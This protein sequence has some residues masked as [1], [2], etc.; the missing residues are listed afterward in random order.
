[1]YP[2]QDDHTRRM[3]Q[4][5]DSRAYSRMSGDRA[6]DPA[7]DDG[8]GAEGGYDDGY[9]EPRQSRR[10]PAIDVGKFVGSVAAT[11]LVAAI[12][13]W[14]IAWVVDAVFSRFGHQWANGGNTPTMY[15]V[16][17]AVAAILAG[18]LWYLLLIGTANPQQFYSWTVGLLIVAA[19]ALPLLVTVPFLDGLAAAIVHLFIGLPILALTSAF[20]AT[21]RR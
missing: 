1:M 6:Y 16:Y 19:V 21:L 12:A 20:S 17:G 2:G 4:Q 8:Y 14:L 10:G 7:H 9:V 3:G 5:P 13:G 11:A 18:L 15:A